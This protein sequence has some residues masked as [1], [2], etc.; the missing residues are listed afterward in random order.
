MSFL[1]GLTSSTPLEGS[2][3][4]AEK[5]GGKYGSHALKSLDSLGF[6]YTDLLKLTQCQAQVRKFL[7]LK[8]RRSQVVRTKLE[9]QRAERRQRLA[10]E[11]AT[12]DDLTAGRTLLLALEDVGAL[13]S[14]AHLDCAHLFTD[15][16]VVVSD[17]LDASAVRLYRVDEDDTVEVGKH[18]H[19][20]MS[21]LPYVSEAMSSGKAKTHKVGATDLEQMRVVCWNDPPPTGLALG[22]PEVLVSLAGEK[23]LQQVLKTRE[24][25]YVAS[26]DAQPS[27]ACHVACVPTKDRRGV[28]VVSRLNRESGE[29]TE[30]QHGRRVGSAS[31]KSRGEDAAPLKRAGAFTAAELLLLSKLTEHV[32]LAM[33]TVETRRSLDQEVENRNLMDKLA[34]QASQPE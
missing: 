24:G 23:T 18:V 2:F 12:L 20:P 8:R 14:P 17:L 22:R 6:G 11:L 7:L 26:R 31:V 10:A 4:R 27:D 28:L 34:A 9:E 16:A 25:V 30:G 15:A 33:R 13:F 21:A 5:R 19:L 3:A 32:R 29:K 1:S